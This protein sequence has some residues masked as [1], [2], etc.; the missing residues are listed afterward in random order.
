M[1][2]EMK[3]QSAREILQIYWQEYLDGLTD[4]RLRRS[5]KET[6][7]DK[8][9][10]SLPFRRYVLERHNIGMDEFLRLNLSTE[11]YAFHRASG[12]S[13]GAANG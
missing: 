5:E 13:D 7:L 4:D 9:K 1:S 11:D 2:L 8:A 3:N 12:Q 6:G 10:S